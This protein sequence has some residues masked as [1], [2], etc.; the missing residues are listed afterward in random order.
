M[1]NPTWII[2]AILIALGFYLERSLG[3]VREKLQRIIE[4]MEDE[5]NRGRK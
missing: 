3:K 1:P 4:L 2:I 5:R